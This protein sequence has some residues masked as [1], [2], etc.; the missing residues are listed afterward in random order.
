L[1]GQKHK[2]RHDFGS[3]AVQSLQLARRLAIGVLAREGEKL[4]Q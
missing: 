1:V 4:L 3:Y 2:I